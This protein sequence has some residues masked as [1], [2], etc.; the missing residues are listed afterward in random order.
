MVSTPRTLRLVRAFLLTAMAAAGG[1]GCANPTSTLIIV[2]NQQPTVDDSGKCAVSTDSSQS[3][4]SDGRYDV[5]LDRAY[6]YFVF[7]LIQNRLPSIKTA[8][9]IERN[10]V[11]LRR[12]Q[13]T[14]HAPPGV[15]PAWDPRCPATFDS[16]ATAV[17]DPAQS[18]AVKVEGM[19]NCHSQRLRELIAEG[20]IPGDTSQPVYFTLELT[21]VADRS[22]S[23]QRSDPFPFQ[24]QVCAG[25]LQSMYPAVPNCAD[26]PKPNPFRG[27]PCNIA[28]DVGLVLCCRDP[29]GALICPS[30]DV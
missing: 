27:N 10:S 5:D 24:V 15:D 26:A 28:Q 16:P 22:G 14:V 13:V 19:R 9:G 3:P 17:L 21:A 29:G 4:S 1:S 2:Q 18:L 30:P 12:V 8:G 6:P 23:E 25:C 20:A 7:P 11:V